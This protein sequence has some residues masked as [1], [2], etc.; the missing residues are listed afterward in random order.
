MGVLV[1]CAS[2]A[3]FGLG[4]DGWKEEILLPDGT[5]VVVKRWQTYGGRH[6]IGQPPPVKERGFSFIMPKIGEQVVWKSE[7]SEEMGWTNFS[8]L[9]LHIQTDSV[10]VV[11]YPYSCLSYNKW[12][13]PNPPYVIFQYRDKTWHRVPLESLPAEAKAINLIIN[14][15]EK[16]IA[17]HLVVPA[18]VIQKLNSGYRQPELQRIAREPIKSGEGSMVNCREMVLYKGAWVGPGDSIGK[19]MMDLEF[20]TTPSQKE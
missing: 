9:A 11:A 17:D 16:S 14:T 13:R 15:T 20:N 19:R 3:P 10:F 5:S 12:G 8:P 18:P 6:E 4:G 1:A 7:Y 2:G